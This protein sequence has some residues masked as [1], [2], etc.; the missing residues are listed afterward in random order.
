MR[1]KKPVVVCFALF[2]ILI[3]SSCVPVPYIHTDGPYRGKVVEL[4]TEEPIEG[5]VV[6]ARWFIVAYIN[7][8]KFCDVQETVTDKNGEFELPMG[9]CVSNI[10][11]QLDNPS[12]VIF[13][14]GYLGYP[15]LGYNQA[16]RQTYMPTFTGDEFKNEK[17]YNVIVIG[18]PKTVDERKLVLSD[19][20][21]FLYV[22]IRDQKIREEKAKYLLERTAI[23]RKN[24]GLP[25]R[26]Q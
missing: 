2:L 16:E 5:A 10:F 11:A 14:P 8:E 18:K 21:S 1:N 15:P 19:V 6:A 17:Q 23:E 24:L 26:R 7:Y 13:K 3:S 25:A 9:W 22:D 4:E 20:E 12:V